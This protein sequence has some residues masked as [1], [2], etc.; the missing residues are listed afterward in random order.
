[1]RGRNFYRGEVWLAELPKVPKNSSSVQAGSRPVLIIQNNIGNKHS[2]T[3]IVATLTSK[4]KKTSLAVHVKLSKDEYIGLEE[5]S[6]ILCEQ[7]RTMDKKR[8]K[9]R[10]FKLNRRDSCRVNN[11]IKVSLGLPLYDSDKYYTREEIYQ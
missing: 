2:P 11:A 10:L 9:S 6:V 4:I 5:D 8:L 1:M 3:V 7:L